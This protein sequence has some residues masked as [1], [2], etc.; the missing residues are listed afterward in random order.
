MVHVMIYCNTR[1]YCKRGCEVK[2]NKFSVIATSF[3]IIYCNTGLIHIVS[4][5]SKIPCCLRCL[6]DFMTVSNDFSLNSV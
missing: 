4:E 2:C 6:I 5:T 3:A 1:F